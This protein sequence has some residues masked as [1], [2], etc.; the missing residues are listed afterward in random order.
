MEREPDFWYS[1]PS[2]LDLAE[3]SPVRIVVQR[4]TRAA[5]RVDGATVAAIGPGILLYA[6]FRPEDTAADLAWMADKVVGLR[7]FADQAGKMNRSVAEVE[8]QILAVSQFTLYGDARKGRRPSFD[9]AAPADAAR[10]LFEQFTDRLRVSGLTVRVGRF[11]EHMQV[12]SENDGPVTILLDSPTSRIASDAP[13]Y[14]HG[15]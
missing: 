14:G 7:I 8:G 6:G 12:E 11:Q 5:V 1:D 4:V 9:G 15:S 10:R 3:A 13:E 2:S